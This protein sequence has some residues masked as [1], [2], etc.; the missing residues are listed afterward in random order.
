MLQYMYFTLSQIYFR[1]KNWLDFIGDRNVVALDLTLEDSYKVIRRLTTVNRDS[2]LNNER[3]FNDL[4]NALQGQQVMTLMTS[5]S[6][7]EV[8]FPI[9]RYSSYLGDI[10]YIIIFTLYI[11]TYSLCVL[12]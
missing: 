9:S 2:Y 10:R 4:H 3:P 11:R 6:F 5:I 12:Q 7:I 8:S 1:L